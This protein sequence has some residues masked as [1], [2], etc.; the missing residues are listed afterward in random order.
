[1]IKV[2]IEA[3]KLCDRTFF[4]KNFI[5]KLLIFLIFP[6]VS[7]GWSSMCPRWHPVPGF[8]QLVG[9]TDHLSLQWPPGGCSPEERGGL[10]RLHR[11]GLLCPAPA[12]RCSDLLRVRGEGET[13]TLLLLLQAAQQQ[14]SIQRQFIPP[15]NSEI[16][17]HEI[18][19]LQD[20]WS[21]FAEEYNGARSP[22]SCL[23]LS[24]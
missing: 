23:Q 10:L 14:Y 19:Q 11:L 4:F 13:P 17:H 1:M 8:S 15:D 21:S 24:Q 22:S 6:G 2:Q 16:W 9:C 7:A 5:L 18:N 3:D 12:R 20:V